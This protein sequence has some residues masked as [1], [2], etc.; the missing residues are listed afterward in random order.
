MG[1]W[2][3]GEVDKVGKLSGRGHCGARQ[4]EEDGESGFRDIVF[5]GS[6]RKSRCLIS[7]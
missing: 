1:D 6:A 2:Q 4:S 7:S 3:V 5:G